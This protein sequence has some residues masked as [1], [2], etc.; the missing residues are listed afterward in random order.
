METHRIH[1]QHVAPAVTGHTMHRCDIKAACRLSIEWNVEDVQQM[2]VKMAP[3][4]EVGLDSHIENSEEA[5]EIW[6]GL[7]GWLFPEVAKPKSILCIGSPRYQGNGDLPQGEVL[8]FFGED[9]CFDRVKTE[10][11]KQLD[12]M[13]GETTELAT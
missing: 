5:L 6:G 10:A 3:G 1:V 8:F 11:G 7:I 9:G 4:R 13:L 2:L 12:S